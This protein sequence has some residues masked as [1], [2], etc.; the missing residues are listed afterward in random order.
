MHKLEL[1]QYPLALPIFLPLTEIHLSLAAT[2]AGNAP[3]AVWLDD[4]EQP[5]VGFAISPEGHYLAG[6]AE[7]SA[8]YAGLKETIEHD[9][10]LVFHPP[11]WETVREQIWV[12]RV[13]A[14][15]E[16]LNLRFQR[17]KLSDWHALLQTGFEFA[18]VDTEFLQ[19][20]SLKNH[21][22]VTRWIR[23]WF[24][25][26]D[27]LANGLGFCIVHD[28]TIASMC[29]MDCRSG[30]TCEIGIRTDPGYRRRGLAAI[31]V[32][33]M[34]DACLERGITTIGWHCHRTNY[35]SRGTAQK[36]GFEIY[37]EY[38]AYSS[39]FPAQNLGDLSQAAATHWAKHFTWAAD[40]VDPKYRLD[41]AAAWALA[42]ESETT[43][44]QLRQAVK[45]GADFT[46]EWLETSWVFT[47]QRNLPAFQALIAEV[48][49]DSTDSI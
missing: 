8:S 35:G 5:R 24:S 41:A 7:Q 27:F 3:G 31:V 36:V 19:R 49:G 25:T 32:A 10:Y 1:T 43:L 20:T 45:E 22:G 38:A 29:I 16:R 11:V 4:L 17:K 30:T 46:P 33:G 18:Q 9:S 13:A 2:L 37:A 12:N 39:F 47:N 15:Q 28:D 48:R 34:V 14:R 42:G 40:R 23:G 21:D 6:D 44:S 26:E